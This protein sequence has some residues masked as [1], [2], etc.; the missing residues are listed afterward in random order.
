MVFGG[1]SGGGGRR[2]RR[3]GWA[4]W[5]HK[6]ILVLGTHP[7]SDAI[8]PAEPCL[9]DVLTSPTRAVAIQRR[10]LLEEVTGLAKGVRQ[11]E[12]GVRQAGKQ[13]WKRATRCIPAAIYASHVPICEFTLK[14]GGPT[15][16]LGLIS[17]VRDGSIDCVDIR[18]MRRSAIATESLEGQL[19]FCQAELVGR[20]QSEGVIRG[21]QVSISDIRGLQAKIGKS[22][23]YKVYM[24]GP[25]VR[26]I[27]RYRSVNSGWQ[28]IYQHYPIED[29]FRGR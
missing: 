28:E 11:I 4:I 14:L 7:Q 10:E 2:L 8:R 12:G 22:L 16:S 3:N 1:C 19:F 13:V 23:K 24:R 18:T 5:L 6:D 20:Y 9:N 27:Y 17:S 26:E 21:G 15:L 25:R 29:Q